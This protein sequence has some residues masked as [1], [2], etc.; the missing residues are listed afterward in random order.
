MH[1]AV[2]F[3]VVDNILVYLNHSANVIIVAVYWLFLR[4][5]KVVPKLM[6]H[7]EIKIFMILVIF[8]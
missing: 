5:G 1:P 2:L 3:H 4:V 7:G 6:Y 8:Q